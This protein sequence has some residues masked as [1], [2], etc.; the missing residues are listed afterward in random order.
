MEWNGYGHNLSNTSIFLE[1][2]EDVL[3]RDHKNIV[4]QTYIVRLGQYS[5]LVEDIK[6]GWNGVEKFHGKS[7]HL[8]N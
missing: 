8:L 7:Q 5:M 6:L 3:V 2:G 4:N 1:Q